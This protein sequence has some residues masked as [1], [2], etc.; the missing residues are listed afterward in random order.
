MAIIYEVNLK[1][2]QTIAQ[3]YLSWLHDHVNEMLKQTGFLQARVYQDISE[4]EQDVQSTCHYIVQYTVATRESLQQYFEHVAPLMRQQG[5][6]RFGDK[7][8]ATRRILQPI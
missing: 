1:V 6:E 3:E 5:I 4:N 7:F 2:V 8:T